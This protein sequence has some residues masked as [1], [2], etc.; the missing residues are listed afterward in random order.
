MKGGF[1]VEKKM[2]DIMGEL[3]GVFD[4]IEIDPEAE[5]DLCR[6]LHLD[7]VIAEAQRKAGIQGNVQ[8]EDGGIPGNIQIE[9]GIRRNRSIDETRFE[10]RKS[11]V[12]KFG[13]SMKWVACAVAAVAL[14]G[15]S[16]AAA[17]NL[18]ALHYFL[19]TKAEIPKGEITNVG[20]SAISGGVK[21]TV[22][23]VLAGEN[24]FVTLLTFVQTDGSAF[25]E[26]TKLYR[27]RLNTEDKGVVQSVI[28]VRM[29]EDRKLLNAFIESSSITSMLNQ[30]IGA[31]VQGIYTEDRRE[32]EEDISLSG[33]FAARP[34][35]MDIP[36]ELRAT[37]WAETII[38]AFEKELIEQQGLFF[39]SI[40]LKG[41]KEGFSF[42]GVGF[43]DGRLSIA[44][45]YPE[46][47]D[48][49]PLA[50]LRPEAEINKLKDRRTGAVYE[51]SLQRGLD[52]AVSGKQM[53]LADFEG[54]QEADLPYLEPIATYTTRNI[55][56]K[57][58]W[59]VSFTVKDQGKNLTLHPDLTIDLHSEKAVLTEANISLL[60][61]Y[62]IGQWSDSEKVGLPE[63]YSTK[64][65]AV[66][67]DGEILKFKISGASSYVDQGG[68]NCFKFNYN[69]FEK[70]DDKNRVLL[71][72]NKLESI[73]TIILDDHEWNIK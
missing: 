73:K 49:D 63:N 36:E 50:Y 5:E 35:R 46:G 61:G 69:L 38:P 47:D 55:L 58:P 65:R 29:S 34:I 39:D 20:Q 16:V 25:P 22:E 21:M 18:D 43:L 10:E 6:G 68:R 9:A 40:S 51:G 37:S 41:E 7:R 70:E 54:L 42:A 27:V 31:E 44:T 30:S 57:G 67:E 24:D 53:L 52:S 32:L 14:L 72:Q 48:N 59:K 3:D 2:I 60:G 12:P 4:E 71:P 13:K 26:G 23:S 17:Q 19:R 66:T 1:D 64:L 62:V 28:G 8:A 45:Y 15:G 33:C 56:E 11:V